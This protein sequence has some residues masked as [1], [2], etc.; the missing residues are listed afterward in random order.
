VTDS[1]T[2]L[3]DRAFHAILTR[4]VETGRAPNHI[5]LGE[6]LGVN[7]DDARKVLHNL[8]ASGYPGWVD[9]ND[10]IVTI[11][12]LS[13]HPNQYRISVDGEQKWFGQLGPNHAASNLI[14]T[15]ITS[16]SPLSS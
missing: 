2:V 3:L 1:N 4:M 12:P 14:L 13:N 8:M 10:N 11:C 9:E 15:W 5:E 6:A 7:P 16:V